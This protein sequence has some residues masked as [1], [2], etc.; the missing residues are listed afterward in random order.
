MK[1]IKHKYISAR[2]LV[3][4]A[5]GSKRFFKFITLPELKIFKTIGFIFS[6][7]L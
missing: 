4:Q 5:Q 7:F 2:D 6:V 3:L 1:Y